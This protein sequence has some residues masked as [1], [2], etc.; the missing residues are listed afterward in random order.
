ME[1]GDR[2]GFVKM[3][4]IAIAKPSEYKNVLNV[5][6]RT[7][8][9]YVLAVLLITT[10]V[11]SVIPVLA[12]GISIGGPKN[13]ITK[14]L[15]AFEYK[16]GTFHIDQRIEI[17][18]D[19]VRIIADSDVEKFKESDLEDDALIELLVSKN[20]MYLKNSAVSQNVNIDFAEVGKGTFDNQDMV[21]ML[22]LLYLGIAIGVIAVFGGSLA[23]YL[24]S[25]LIFAICGQT[26]AKRQ[27]KNFSFGQCYIF[28][29]MAKASVNIINSMGNAADIDFFQSVIWTFISFA[30]ILAYMY[31][32]IRGPK[33]NASII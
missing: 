10:F 28:A 12:F 23:G 5:K 30:A 14:T 33:Q 19:G 27:N 24:I 15:P 20:N 25:A 29:L 17:D 1:Q 32:G 9:A 31:M 7:I 16:D 11:G 22:P 6:K 26:F 13:F 18:Q 8:V 2:I 4:G 21:E 3:L